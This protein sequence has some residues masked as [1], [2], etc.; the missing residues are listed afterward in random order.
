MGG[1]GVDIYNIMT[2]SVNY[3]YYNNLSSTD[4]NILIVYEIIDINESM[5][6]A[7]ECTS[8]LWSRLTLL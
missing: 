8:R 5:I 6:I 4:S 3:T 7:S 2:V 1:F